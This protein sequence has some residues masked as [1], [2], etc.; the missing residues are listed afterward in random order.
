MELKL[1][2]G[3]Y[4]PD[5]AGGFEALDGAQAALA[6][7]LFRL[8]ARRGQFPFLPELGSRLWRLGQVP[9]ADRQSAAEQYVAE[10]LAEEPGLVVEEV[11]MAETGGGRAVAYDV[12]GT[13]LY[14][15]DAEGLLLEM[16]ADTEYP[17]LAATLNDEGWLAV[18]AEKQNYK[19]AVTVYNADMEEA[20]EFRSSDRFVTDFGVIRDD[21]AEDT[22]PADR[23]SRPNRRGHRN[24]HVHRDLQDRR[25]LHVR[26]DTTITGH[27]IPSMSRQGLTD[28]G[29]T[30][31]HQ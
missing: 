17:F 13:E 16:T 30:A 15:L 20:F 24:R 27:T 14:V 28:M 3:D 4:V 22:I 6:R 10:A 7:A 19:G 5:G 29:L 31:T 26:Q 18:T 2:Q 12:G 1:E 21:P 23:H 8:T 25:G 9:A 11:A